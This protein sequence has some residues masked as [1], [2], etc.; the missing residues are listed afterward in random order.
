[1]PDWHAL[2]AGYAAAVDWPAAAFWPEL[3][4]AFPEALVVLS[5]RDPEDWYRSASETIF[6]TIRQAPP[7]P[8]RDMVEALFASRFTP[9]LDDRAACLAAYRAH[10]ERV[11]RAVPPERLLEWRAEDG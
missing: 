7:G 5:R 1:M 10:T 6:P 9:A 4:A 2:L 8:W 3:S 11:R